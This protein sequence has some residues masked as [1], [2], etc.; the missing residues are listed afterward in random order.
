MGW[1]SR[2]KKVDVEEI[3]DD[4]FA[5]ALD[6]QKTTGPFDVAEHPDRGNLLD[7]GSLW[8]PAVPGYQIQFSLDKRSGKIF[9]IVYTKDNAALQLQVFAAPRSRGIWKEV[10]GD[11][12]T[13]IAKQGGSSKDSEGPYGPELQSMVPVPQIQAQQPHR[14]VGIDGPRW[15]LRA[16]F[17]GVA[18]ANRTVSDRMMADIVEKI[19]VVRGQNPHPPRELLNLS[20]PRLKGGAQA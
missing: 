7:A 9:G 17:Y 14:F 19:V 4:V 18:G 1:F 12:R 10:L 15:L 8:I 5:E 20:M 11:M 16:T 3:K 6:D 2:K 13:S